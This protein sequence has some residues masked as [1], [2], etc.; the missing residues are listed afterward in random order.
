MGKTFKDRFEEEKMKAEM[1][2]NDLKLWCSEHKAELAVFG[3]PVIAA[4]VE[5]VK[6][7]AK[8]S[9]VNEERHLKENYIY[10]RSMGHYYELRRKLKSSE[11]LQIEQRKREGESLGEILQDM[12]VLK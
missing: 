9:T 12:R 6:T 7:V 5:L 2:L 11:W 8:R 4:I 1:K 10:D 3:P